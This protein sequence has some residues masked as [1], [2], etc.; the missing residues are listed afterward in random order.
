MFPS[1]LIYGLKAPES[2]LQSDDNEGYREEQ[3]LVP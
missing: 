3:K 2:L 1:S